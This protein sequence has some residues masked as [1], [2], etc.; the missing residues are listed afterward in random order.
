MMSMVTLEDYAGQRFPMHRIEAH[1]P[2]LAVTSHTAVAEVHGAGRTAAIAERLHDALP[3]V[4]LGVAMVW[5]NDS[6]LVPSGKEDTEGTVDLPRKRPVGAAVLVGIAIGVVGM[7]V[8]RWVSGS[9]AAAVIV[10]VFLVVVGGVI[11]A[12]IGGAGRYAGERAWE[13]E[14]QGDQV[15][16]MVALFLSD[17]AAATHAAA[18]IE[19]MGP[20]DVRIV[21]EDGGWHAPNT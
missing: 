20:Y 17:E 4:P 7:F 14:R 13:Q 6:T 2:H 16:G 15:I 5:P 11:G 19:A 1:P 3:D 12:L 18:A 21:G 10:G 8:A 9:W